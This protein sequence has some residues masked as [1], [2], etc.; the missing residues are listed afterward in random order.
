MKIEGKTAL[1]TGGASGLGEASVRRLH[2]QGANIVI[3][4]MKREPG[5]ALCAELGS[6]AVFAETD[7][8]NTENVQS[9]V[10]L[11]MEKFG[12]VHILVN[13]AGTGW[14]QKTVGREGPHDL[15]VFV[16][17]L[18]LNLVATFD[19]VRLAAFQMQNNEPNEDGERGVIIN[20]ASVAAFDGQMGQVAYAASKAGVVGMPLVVARD[21]ARS[22]VRCCTIAPGTFETP[23]T[24]FMAPEARD[25]L[26]QQTPFPKRFGRPDEFAMLVQQIT[27]NSFMNGETIRL[28]GSIRMPAK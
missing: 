21:M 14:I 9:A 11:A 22:G 23:L 15:D 1:I 2:A 27:E 13:C 20:T 4:D 5:E 12:A 26:T 8:T 25:A 16:K 19:A 18:N 17:I 28:D 6:R 3:V 7:V 24:G 10:N